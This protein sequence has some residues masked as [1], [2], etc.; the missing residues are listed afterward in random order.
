MKK[1][2][3]QIIKF[4]PLN[5]KTITFTPEPKP[6]SKAIPEWYKQQPG[7]MDNGE[8]LSKFG[9][10]TNTVKKCLPIFDAITAGYILVAPSDIFIDASDPEKLTYQ[11]PAPLS[12]F[13]ADLFASHERKQY[14]YLPMPADVYHQDLLRIMPFWIASTPPGYSALFLDPINRDISPLTAITGIIDTD[15]YPSDGH[16]SF[17]VQAGFVGVIKQ[18]T[19]LVQIIPFKREDWKME[20]AD[21][22]ESE[23]FLKKHRMNLR[24]TFSNGYKNKFRSPKEYK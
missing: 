21:P 24:S 16:F 3:H 4:Y 7:T 15:G 20:V 12:P 23:G 6:A 14:S 5:D 10:P 19:P 18:G 22:Q 1:K 8:S 11:I 13:K 9:Q 2:S 17:K